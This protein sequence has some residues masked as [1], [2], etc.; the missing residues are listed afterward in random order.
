M[1]ALFQETTHSYAP[2]EAELKFF[3]E[4][5]GVLYAEGAG[6]T[7]VNNEATR[8]DIPGVTYKLDKN[9]DG[10]WFWVRKGRW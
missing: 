2:T 4:A 3:S 5:Q 1:V 10:E 6:F 9:E 7:V 8:E